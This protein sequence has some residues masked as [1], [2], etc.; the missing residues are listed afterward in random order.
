MERRA[1]TSIFGYSAG[2]GG[3]TVRVFCLLGFVL[4]CAVRLN[5]W[6]WRDSTDFLVSLALFRRVGTIEMVGGVLYLNFR[7]LQFGVNSFGGWICAVGILC[8]IFY[9][10]S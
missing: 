7:S 1:G 6:G 3:G 10:I 8:F 5:R 2:V 4:A 9:V